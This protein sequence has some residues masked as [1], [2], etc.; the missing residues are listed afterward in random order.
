MVCRILYNDKTI[1]KLAKEK[2]CGPIIYDT[3]TVNF[4]LQDIV[5]NTRK[6]IPGRKDSENK[7]H[8]QI[9]PPLLVLAP[10]VN[11]VVVGIG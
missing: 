3:I 4:L 9:D 8:C 5:W 2:V 11:L 7:L 10:P 1:S 6:F